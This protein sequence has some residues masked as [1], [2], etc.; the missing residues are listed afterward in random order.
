MVKLYSGM[1]YCVIS[2]LNKMAN[3]SKA[4]QFKMSEMRSS[5]NL[6]DSTVAVSQ[7]KAIARSLA[8]GRDVLMDKNDVIETAIPNV[9][10]VKESIAFLDSKRSFYYSMPL[11]YINGEQTTG[12][13]TTGEAD[14]KAVERGLKAYYISILKPAVEAIFEVKTSFKSMDFRQ[15]ASALEAVKT[16]E[17]VSDDF[18]SKENKQLIVS[19]LFDVELDGQ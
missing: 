4:I 17:L 19:K 1:E 13:G 18:I 5:V 3:L 9:S 8:N 10:T 6:T 11:S 16:F 2:S 7:A 12:I 15:I 14:A